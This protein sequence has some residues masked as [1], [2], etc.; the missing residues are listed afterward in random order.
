MYPLANGGG[1]HCAMAPLSDT[2]KMYKQYSSV[3]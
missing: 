3:A 1:D 2:K